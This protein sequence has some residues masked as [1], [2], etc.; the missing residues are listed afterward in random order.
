[1]FALTKDKNGQFSKLL[2]IFRKG[3]GGTPPPP[4][5]GAFLQ[6]DGVS[7]ILLEDGTSKLLLEA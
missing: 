1:M 7:F 4:G 2:P 3:Q 5:G 6:E